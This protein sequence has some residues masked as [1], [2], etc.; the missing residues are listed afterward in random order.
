MAVLLLPGNYSRFPN[1][2]FQLFGII[3]M[4]RAVQGVDRAEY[5]PECWTVLFLKDGSV[6]WPNT[7]QPFIKQQCLSISFDEIQRQN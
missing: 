6:R 3:K 1:D 2:L 5:S 7:V 4:L